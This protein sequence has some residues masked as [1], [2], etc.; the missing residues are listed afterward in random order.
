MSQEN[1]EIVRQH[2]A[3][4]S[5]EEAT[6]ALS[7]LDPYIV[8]DLSRTGGWVTDEAL[9]GPEAVAEHFRRYA[10]AFEDYRWTVQ[11]LTDLGAGAVLV[12]T[13]ESGRGKGSGVSV[14]RPLAVLYTL[15]DGKVVRITFFEDEQEALKAAGLPE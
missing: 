6:L 11:R 12:V 1:V 13:I 3:A 4:W 10:G 9:Y 14:E 15:V 5:A 2:I 7:F 8:M